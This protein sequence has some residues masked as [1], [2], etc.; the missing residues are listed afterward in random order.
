MDCVRS[1][2]YRRPCLLPE[3]GLQIAGIKSPDERFQA[4]EQHANGS[5]FEGR[6]TGCS[7]PAVKTLFGLVLGRPAVN[8][9]IGG[10]PDAHEVSRIKVR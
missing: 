8:G 6:R 2:P 1:S 9:E 5:D 10:E 7:R 4:A 3:P